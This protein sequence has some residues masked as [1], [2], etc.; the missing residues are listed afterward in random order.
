MHPWQF[1]NEVG[2]RTCS[3]LL[4]LSCIGIILPTAATHMVEGM[5]EATVLSISRGT[6]VILLFCYIAYLY[7]QVRGAEGGEGDNWV[8]SD[9]KALDAEFPASPKPPPSPPA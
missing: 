3:A 4:V 6:A 8:S 1:Y 7:F 5:D 2:N 9:Q